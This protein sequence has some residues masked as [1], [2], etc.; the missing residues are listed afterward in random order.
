MTAKA[1]MLEVMSRKAVSIDLT[2]EE[3]SVLRSRVAMRNA[4]AGA[5]QRARIV[6][7]ASEGRTNDAIAG[8]LQLNRHSVALWRGGGGGGHTRGRPGAGCGRGGVPRRG[9]GG[10]WGRG[11]GRGG[12]PA[13]VRG[14]RPP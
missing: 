13:H 7:A 4:P 14:G 2:P 1:I 3:E 10:C 12:T 6:L 5:V 8:S 9:G 11:F